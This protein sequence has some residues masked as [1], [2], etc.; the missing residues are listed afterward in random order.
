METRLGVGQAAR[1][2]LFR[3]LM[4][5]TAA[6]YHALL[7][8]RAAEGDSAVINGAGQERRPSVSAWEMS[9]LAAVLSLLRRSLRM[10]ARF[11]PSVCPASI[12]DPAGICNMIFR[13]MFPA[14]PPLALPVCML[15]LPRSSRV[16]HCLFLSFSTHSS[17]TPSRIFT[18]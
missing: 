8:D 17:S 14:E 16:V 13:V 18:D 6:H 15:G 3:Q 12:T 1:F 11:G 4:W 10:V 5:H 9:G 7:C 2:P